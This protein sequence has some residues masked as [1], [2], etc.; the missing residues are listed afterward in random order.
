MKA[1]IFA[2]L[3]TLVLVSAAWAACYTHTVIT[4]RG[5]VTCMTCCWGEYSCTTTCF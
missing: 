2:I 3:L 5:S 4:P 1:L